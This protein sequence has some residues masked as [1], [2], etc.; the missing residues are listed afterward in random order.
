MATYTEKELNARLDLSKR[1]LSW[2]FQEAKKVIEGLRTDNDN[3]RKKIEVM[4]ANETLR[5]HNECEIAFGNLEQL[6]FP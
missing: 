3:L 1:Q 6:W 4:N 5:L 2:V